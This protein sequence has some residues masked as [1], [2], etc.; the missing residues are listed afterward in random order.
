MDKQLKKELW[1][2]I[3]ALKCPKDFKCYKSGLEELCKAMY[4]EG[5]ASFLECRE[6]ESQECVFSKHASF[7]DHSFF[8]CACPLRK[9]LASKMQP[10]KNNWSLD[11]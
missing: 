3:G 2:I 11:S 8:I 10:Q 5:V 9:Y 7:D 1:K 6:E 4:V